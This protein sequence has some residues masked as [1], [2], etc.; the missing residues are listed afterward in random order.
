[1]R[2]QSAIAK[3]KEL[4][5]YIV[6]Q[7]I[8]KGLDPRARRSYGSGNGTGEKAD[9]WTSLTIL[10]RN[11]GIEAKNHSV[12]HIKDWWEQTKKLE[13]LGR[14]PVLVY[15]LFGESL[16]EAKAVIYFSTLMDMAKTNQNAPTGQIEANKPKTENR[17]LMWLIRSGVEILKKIIKEF[18]KL[19]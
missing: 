3:G 13:K 4:E 2:P 16:E 10:G 6:S 1:M 15:K 12:P 17:Q 8:E 9:I 14:E 19:I 18:E 7:L 11:V 5:N